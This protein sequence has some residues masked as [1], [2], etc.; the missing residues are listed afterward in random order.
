MK[1][2]YRNIEDILH[3]YRQR[4]DDILRRL[5]EFKS[6]SR[7]LYFYELAYCCMTPQ[8]SASHCLK[9]QQ[10][11]QSQ[12]FLHDPIDPEPILRRKESYIRFHKTKALRLITIKAQFPVIG[13]VIISEKS[14]EVKR[15]WLVKNV[16]GLSYKEATHF[17]RNIGMNEN[18]AILDRHILK[19]LKWHGIL[20]SIPKTLTRK[21]YLGIEKKFQRFSTDIGISL[22]ELDLVFW[23]TETGF[24]LK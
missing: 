4:K 8:S 14:A 15:E 7:Q 2:P 3:A 23:S 9:A 20:R 5:E 1:S 12:N 13:E 21:R 22:N 10:M 18:L 17:L 6:V 16:N 19:N 11:L 24:V